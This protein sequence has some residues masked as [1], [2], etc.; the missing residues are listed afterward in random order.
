MREH[1]IRFWNSKL[2]YRLAGLTIACFFALTLLLSYW[3]LYPYK[4]IEF[5]NTPFPVFNSPI[6]RGEQLVLVVNYN[7]RTNLPAEVASQF[8]NDVVVSV[9]SVIRNLPSGS[10]VTKVVDV[11]VPFCLT[12]DKYFLRQ[13]LTYKVNPIREIVVVVDSQ[14]FE[15]LDGRIRRFSSGGTNVN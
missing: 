12:S 6:H 2:L 7:K 9:P 13:T 3:L 8:M 5:K 4:P 14:P 11:A 10:H 15:V 1:L